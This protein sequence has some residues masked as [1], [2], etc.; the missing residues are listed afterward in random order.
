MKPSDCAPQSHTPLRLDDDHR[1]FTDGRRFSIEPGVANLLWPPELSEI[2][3]K[4]KNQYDRVAERIYEAALNWQFAV[5]VVLAGADGGEIAVA[6]MADRAVVAE[7]VFALCRERLPVYMRPAQAVQ[8]D[9][10]PR[11]ANGKVDRN[12]AKALLE[13]ADQR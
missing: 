3:T 2:E 13:Q 4:T 12:A 11:N 10:L 7:E 8:F 5:A 6:Y 9:Q 1:V